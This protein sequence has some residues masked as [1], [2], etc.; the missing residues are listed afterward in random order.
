MATELKSN[1]LNF[2]NTSI[3]EVDG[4]LDVLPVGFVYIQFPKQKAPS[5]MFAG[6]WDNISNLYP[7]YFFRSEGGDAST[8]S[9]SDVN[10]QEEGL[11]NIEGRVWSSIFW[12]DF[13]G[14]QNGAFNTSL[15]NSDWA[16]RKITS[17]QQFR[18]GVWVNFDA[19]KSNSIYGN[20]EH[21][22]PVNTA[23]R[24]WVRSS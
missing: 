18:S 2:E 1:T 21:V 15:E 19:S 17:S 20:S 11:P 5:E 22:T 24:I 8:F 4:K 3:K 14:N 9:E 23:I 7:G 16:E 13:I 12:K 10:V 6:Q